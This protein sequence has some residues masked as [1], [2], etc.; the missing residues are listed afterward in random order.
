[1]LAMLNG[2]WPPLAHSSAAP[3]PAVQSSAAWLNAARPTGS[4][5]QVSSGNT[6][7]TSVGAAGG[8]APLPATPLGYPVVD[9]GGSKVKIPY[10][11]P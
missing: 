10:L 1:M 8:A 4:G 2:E 9:Y 5:T 3:T 7:S 11:E 6:T